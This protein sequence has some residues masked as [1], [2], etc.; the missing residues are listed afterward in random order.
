M[1][2]LVDLVILARQEQAEDEEGSQL[3]GVVSVSADDVPWDELF[4]GF[5]KTHGLRHKWEGSKLIR[6]MTFEEIK[7]DSELESFERELAQREAAWAEA[8]QPLQTHVIQTHYLNLNTPED[9]KTLE[10]TLT[11]LLTPTPLGLLGDGSGVPSS[12]LGMVKV[13]A[14]NGLIILRTTAGDFEAI[15]TV[16]DT[17][18][19]PPRQVLISAHIVETNRDTARKLGVQWG[20]LLQMG[21]SWLTPG[22]NAGN[23]LGNGIDTPIAP[24]AGQAANFPASID[25]V[26][27]L[28]LGLATQNLGH[29][30]LNVQ[31]SALEEKGELTIISEPKI[32]TMDN[33]SAYI[34]SG[35]EVPYQVTTGT[36]S[37]A[38]NVTTEWKRAVLRLEV[39]P[40]VVNDR[41]LILKITTNK[42][43]LAEVARVTNLPD[44]I[45]KRAETTVTLAN[46]ATTIIGGLV[47]HKTEGADAGVPWLM[48]VP[49]LGRLFSSSSKTTDNEEILI[50]ITPVILPETPSEAEEPGPTPPPLPPPGDNQPGGDVQ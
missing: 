36:G 40:K 28:D 31:L 39:T 47:K 3:M 33:Q 41:T 2:K 17:L 20:G 25:G 15:R 18:N 37:N 46:G 13:D 21:Q 11:G 42:D 44:V 49:F 43:E 34:E 45:T 7:R 48:D 14:K 27:A 5:L 4:L 50:F 30:I 24:T 19:R 16:I 6:V 1:G 26:S 35:R 12:K 8:R 10:D 38:S 9:A 23:I 22:A 29:Y 32:T